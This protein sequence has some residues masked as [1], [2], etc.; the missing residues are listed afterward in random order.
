M[1]EVFCYVHPYWLTPQRIIFFLARNH[2]ST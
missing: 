2:R 1:L